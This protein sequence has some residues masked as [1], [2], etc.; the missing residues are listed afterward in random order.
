MR[1]AIPGSARS[2][3]PGA[4]DSGFPI[5]SLPYGTIVD[6]HGGETDVVRIGDFALNL[7]QLARDGLLL[8]GLDDGDPLMIALSHGPETLA[9][10][11][12][13]L[14]AYLRADTSLM[15]SVRERIDAALI[16]LREVDI[17]MPLPVNAFVDF[18]SGIHHAS[19]VGRM[20]RP[21]QPPLLPNYRHLP[22]GY[23]GRASS[24]VVSGYPIVR[25]LGQSKGA[26]DE[27]PAFGPTKELDFELELG[28]FTSF[29]TE[30]G[31]MTT[32]DEVEDLILG[33]VLVNDWSARD[34]QRW[35]YQPLGPFLA[36]SFATSISPWIVPFD[37]LEA[38][39]VEGLP[40]DPA[41][42]EYLQ[43]PNLRALD[44]HLEVLLRTAQAERAQ[45]I[46]RTNA[47]NLYWSLRQ[48]LAHQCSNGTPIGAG[49]L[50]ATGTISGEKKGEFGS[51]LELTWRGQEPITIEETGETRTFLEDGDTVIMRGWCEGDGYQ[52]S[53][54]EVV[55][56]IV[57]ELAE[58]DHD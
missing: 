53:L 6:D 18:Y 52:I 29:P 9:E 30:M 8:D 58:W 44:I 25:P 50:Y 1:F 19:N 32:V 35:E 11:R 23:N 42:L 54:G 15:P 28:M 31:V 47:R 3:V 12:E 26:Q 36:K 37:A 57:T 33:C 5:Q 22:I 51:L 46:C 39:R 20:F 38:F 34:F 48:Q 43:H 55:G 17:E 10:I 7:D 40:Q 49:D 56:T 41:P 13:Q 2:W 21:D 27:A 14:Y 45:V 4:D 16:P 24:V